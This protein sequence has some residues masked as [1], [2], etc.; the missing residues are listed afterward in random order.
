MN[1]GRLVSMAN[2]IATSFRT[3]PEQQAA[4][5]T[6]THIRQF[7][8]PRMRKTLLAHLETGGDGLLPGARKAAELLKAQT[9]T[10][11]R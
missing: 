8:D 6:A 5:S 11:A 1:E 3:L 9:E 10:P 4:E 7:W 2:Q